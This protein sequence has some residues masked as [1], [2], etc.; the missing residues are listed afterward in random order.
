MENGERIWNEEVKSSITD[1][2]DENKRLQVK[3]C[4]MS[5]A[6]LS[7]TGGL[8]ARE[9]W[10]LKGRFKGNWSTMNT[11]N[12]AISC[13][14]FLLSPTVHIMGSDIFPWSLEALAQA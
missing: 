2:R 3:P 1:R 12:Q 9:E 13:S 14:L 6:E 4:Y 8:G 11:Q 10:K 5:R 7:E